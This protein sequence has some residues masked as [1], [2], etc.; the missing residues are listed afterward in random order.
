MDPNTLN[1]IIAVGVVILLAILVWGIRRYRSNREK[2]ANVT[3]H[4]C[5][6]SLD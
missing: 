1:C 2:K 3:R 4:G 5:Q 6:A